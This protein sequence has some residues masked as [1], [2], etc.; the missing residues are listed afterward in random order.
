[1]Q[2]SLKALINKLNPTSK[3]ALEQGI[4]LSVSRTHFNIEIE[5]WLLKLLE[6]TNNDLTYVLRQYGIDAA[7]VKRELEQQLSRLKTGNSRPGAI[8]EEIL[9]AIREAWIFASLEQGSPQIRSAHL[10]AAMLATRTLRDRITNSSPELDKISVEKLQAEMKDLLPRVASKE[11]DQE[12]A[13]AAISGPSPTAPTTPGGGKT[14]ALDQFTVNLTAKAK[15]GAI[16]PVVGRDHEIRQVVDIL[17]RRRQNNP[18]LTGEAGVG[19]TAVVEGL[20]LRIISGDVPHPLKS[21]QLHTL[22]LGL[23]QAGAGVKGEFENRL[24]SVIDE[25]KRSPIPIILFID[26]AHTLIGA[27]GAAG[28]NDAANLLKPALAR[29]ELRTIAAT[30]FAE[31]KKYFETDAA[32]K[33]RFQQVKVDEPDELKAIRMLRGLVA[34]LEKHHK[35]RILD[36][37]VVDAVRLSTRYMPD[38]QL[39]DKAVSLLDTVCARVALSQSATPPTLDDTRKELDHLALEIEFLEREGRVSSGNPERVDDL[40]QQKEKAESRRFALE[41]QLKK[42]KALVEKIQ[43][44]REAIEKTSTAVSEDEKVELAKLVAE[45]IAVQ[46]ENPLVYPVAHGGA[47][48]QVVSGLTGI[49]LGKMVRDEVGTVLKLADILAER[50]VGQKHALEAISQRI[51]TARADLADPRRPQGVFLLV[52][53]SGVGKTET[54]LAL[55]DLLYGGDRNMV[56]VNM[57]EYKES[58]KVSRLVGTS[59]GYVGYGE[60]GVL[61]NAVKNR[62][63]SVVLLDEV[64]KAH[65]SVQ[66]IFYQVFDKGVLQN[67]DGEDVNFKN[68]IILLTSNVGTD[69]IMKA[70][71][72]PDTAP[73][74][75]GLAEMLKKDLLKAFKPALLGRMTVVPYYP[76]GDGVLKKIIQLKLNQIGDRLKQ[77][78]KAKF[79]YSPAVVET[80]SARCKDVDTGARNA[81]HIITGSV[82]TE[83][84]AQVLTRIAEGH[85]VKGV[86]VG[87]DGESKMTY[88]VE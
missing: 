18:I 21:V 72:D 39:P 79:T 49:P 17:T 8:A 50:V 34:M 64:E 69:T 63:Y 35:V 55:A 40:K 48:A 6:G 2:V 5:H 76:L 65:E 59:K 9:D 29:G 84:S 58:H 56:I 37:A 80:I 30:T 51:R 14:P 54:A 16:D 47:V 20:A 88:A 25:V 4:A 19:K 86:T 45:L 73:S 31:Y 38:R 71:A 52:G 12:A 68:T 83:I 32:L 43:T 27:G 82:L 46:G 77:N 24:K 1:M 61:T 10:L 44:K 13:A 74:P 81:D 23:L 41:E 87:V 33:R 70:C 28:Q 57:S 85:T 67:D 3:E 26:E 42:E 60:G 7:K 15:A 75:E 62:P 78:Y 66:E 22:D 53:P 36:E 11:N